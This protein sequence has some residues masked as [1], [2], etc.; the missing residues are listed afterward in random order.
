MRA[1]HQGMTIHKN[2]NAELS[3]GHRNPPAWQITVRQDNRS[4]LL[5]QDLLATGSPS[6]V[7]LSVPLG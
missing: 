6:T 4:A 1:R 2:F 7:E 5:L 3:P